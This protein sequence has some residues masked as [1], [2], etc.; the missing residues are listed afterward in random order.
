[1]SDTSRVLITGASG[2]IGT[3]LTA[4]LCQ[5]HGRDRVIA[6]DLKPFPCVSSVPFERLDVTD[7][8]AMAQ[9]VAKHRVDAIFHLAAIL[10]AAGERNPQRC[11]HVNVQGLCNVLEVAREQGVRRV[12]C[13]S[14]IAV[15]GP[16]TPRHNTPQDTVLR[17]TTMY[18]VTKVAGEL[19][20]HYYFKRYGLDVRGLRYPGVISSQ[21]LPSGG[22]TDYAVE[23]F[24]E[25]VK[26]HA[27]TCFLEPDTT[28][29]MVYMP[30]VI[31]GTIQLAEADLGRLRHHTDFNIAAFSVSPRELAAEI[32]RHIPDFAIS[33]AP[34]FRQELAASWPQSID[35]SA[36]R[37]QWG[38]Q[39]E[40]DLAAMTEEML[41]R[42]GQRHAQGDL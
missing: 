31:R 9:L 25:A 36:A 6:T 20:G 35:D 40:Y 5:R 17:P 15:F 3:E 38:W 26:H 4:A 8:D 24:Y 10:S 23:I 21:V 12:I 42:L 34:D 13:P 18:G 2:Q 28:L 33:Y 19:L 30:D 14:S 29:P 39:P 7:R 1:M 32:A 41:V 11:W 37:A 16:E 22:T 27:Y